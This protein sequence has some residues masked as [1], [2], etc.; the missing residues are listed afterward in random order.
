MTKAA[1][2]L[3][4]SSQESRSSVGEVTVAAT[5]LGAAGTAGG[6]TTARERTPD[7]VAPTAS[8]MSTSKL[9]LPSVVRVPVI[10]AGPAAELKPARRAP[11]V[12]AEAS[13]GPPPS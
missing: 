7:D 10:R 6:G 9:L 3:A 2:W 8:V 12:L 4:L 13:R 5:L 1:V 11:P